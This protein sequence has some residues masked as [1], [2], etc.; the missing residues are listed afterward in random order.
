MRRS[1]C[2]R[3]AARGLLCCDAPAAT[4]TVRPSVG[5][6]QS[7][8]PSLRPSVGLCPSLHPVAARRPQATYPRL[9][10]TVG[11]LCYSVRGVQPCQATAGV[12][13]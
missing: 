10:V 4:G 2:S 3:I 11:A 13:R 9:S 7:V 1:I 8:R 5:V 6:L 12:A